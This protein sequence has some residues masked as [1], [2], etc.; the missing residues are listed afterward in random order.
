MLGKLGKDENNRYDRSDC[1]R[2]EVS[3]VLSYSALLLDGDD[4]VALLQQPLP[5]SFLRIL[6]IGEIAVLLDDGGPY[7]VASTAWSIVL[8]RRFS[9]SCLFAER[10]IGAR[11]HNCRRR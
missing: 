6:N 2:F 4:E 11:I 3:S 10:P 7:A 9:E 8:R 1:R 5:V